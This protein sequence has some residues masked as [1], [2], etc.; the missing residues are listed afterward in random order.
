MTQ[1][2]PEGTVWKECA[3]WK[4]AE[5]K[6]KEAENAVGENHSELDEQE[7]GRSTKIEGKKVKIRGKLARH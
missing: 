1:C 7:L 6:K 3:K 2:A 4:P 5:K